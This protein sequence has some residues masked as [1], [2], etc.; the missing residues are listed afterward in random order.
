MSIIFECKC[1]KRFRSKDEYAGKK[2]KCPVCGELLVI[3]KK[4]TLAGSAVP[5]TDHNIVAADNL[6]SK[7]RQKPDS[8]ISDSELD[9]LR[10]TE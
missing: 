3:E 9:Q 10:E 6:L 7:E 2:M 1:G 8:P 4:E 5:S